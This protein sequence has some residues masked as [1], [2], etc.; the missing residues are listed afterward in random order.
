MRHHLG[1][2][3][4]RRGEASIPSLQAL[5]QRMGRDSRPRSTML[6]RKRGFSSSRLIWEKRSISI[7]KDDA[8][9]QVCERSAE[10]VMDPAPERQVRAVAP[11]DIEPVG[12]VEHVRVP[13]GR[14]EKDDDVVA[15]P[16]GKAVR[17]VI[18]YDVGLFAGLE[19]V[20]GALCDVGF[21]A[22]GSLAGECSIS[23]GCKN[24]AK[25]SSHDQHLKAIS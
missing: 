20:D 19:G 8:P 5:T 21:S 3:R 10:A 1:T 15:S 22:C 12:V 17:P 4:C 2:S 18:P 23:E 14:A 6:L 7:L 25:M 11:A 16:H 13:V 9:F 24:C